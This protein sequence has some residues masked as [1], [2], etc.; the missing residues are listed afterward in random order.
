MLIAYFTEVYVVEFQKRGL[1]HAHI[2]LTVASEDKP[3]CPEDVD[4]LISAEI[5][6]QTTDPLAYETVTKFMVHGP[7]VSCLIDGKCSKLYPKRFCNQTT[8]DEHGFSLYRRRRNLQS[9][10]VNGLEINNQWVVP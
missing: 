10:V 3:I 7:C 8:F 2:L 9:V 1:P 5:P 6:D 4:R